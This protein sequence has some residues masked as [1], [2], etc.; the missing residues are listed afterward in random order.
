M[1]TIATSP[2][3]DPNPSGFMALSH[4]HDKHSAGISA[5]V[6]GKQKDHVVVTQ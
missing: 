2:F 6:G 1:A 3:A 5:T 4:T